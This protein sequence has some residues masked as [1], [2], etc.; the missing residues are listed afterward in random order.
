M[1]GV[2]LRI[3]TFTALCGGAVALVAAILADADS[4]IRAVTAAAGA[5]ILAAQFYSASELIRRGEP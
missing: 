3:L 4:T 5:L 1:A 2:V